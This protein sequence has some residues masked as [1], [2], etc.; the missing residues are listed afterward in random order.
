MVLFHYLEKD[1]ILYSNSRENF[2]I[3]F[4]DFE[5]PE[6]T[7]Y[8]FSS[9]KNIYEEILNKKKNNSIG[10]ST[11]EGTPNLT[12][13]TREKIEQ[14][15]I[16]NKKNKT[17]LFINNLIINKLY[18]LNNGTF[19]YDDIKNIFFVDNNSQ[20][21]AIKPEE[22]YNLKKNQTV[23]SNSSNNKL[24]NNQYH[25]M[26]EYQ[27][28]EKNDSIYKLTLLLSHNLNNDNIEIKIFDCNL[29]KHK[30]KKETLNTTKIKYSKIRENLDR[31]LSNNLYDNLSKRKLFSDEIFKIIL[32]NK[33]DL[34]NILK[35]KQIIGKDKAELLK[36]SFI[37]DLS[38]SNYINNLKTLIH[39]YFV[40]DKFV[41]TIDDD[42]KSVKNNTSK[43]KIFDVIEKSKNNEK[44]IY[45]VNI[46]NTYIQELINDK[47][48]MKKNIF[49]INYIKNT[50][51]NYIG[52]I[53]YIQKEINNNKFTINKD[54]KNNFIKNI[55]YIFTGINATENNNNNPYILNYGDKFVG[56]LNFVENNNELKAT[57]TFIHS[58]KYDLNIYEK[59]NILGLKKL[60]KDECINLL[61]NESTNLL[62]TFF[63]KE[64]ID[65]RL[66]DQYIDSIEKNNEKKDKN[67][68]FKKIFNQYLIDNNINF[69]IDV[70]DNNFILKYGNKKYGEFTITNNIKTAII[71]KNN[72]NLK[73][74]FDNKGLISIS[75]SDHIIP[76]NKLMKLDE[77]I[78]TISFHE[79]AKKF[80]VDDLNVVQTYIEKVMPSVIVIGTQHSAR[81]NFPLGNKDFQTIF[82]K[83]MRD[84]HY[85]NIFRKKSNVR[86]IELIK[87]KKYIKL[88]VYMNKNKCVKINKNTK[89]KQENKLL[90]Y[91]NESIQKN[92]SNDSINNQDKGSIIYKMNMEINGNIKNFIFVNTHIKKNDSLKSFKDLILKHELPNKYD[93][94][95]N[96]FFFG[97]LNAISENKNQKKVE[98]IKKHLI[99][100]KDLKNNK[101]NDKLYTMINEHI[102]LY[103]KPILSLNNK[104]KEIIKKFYQS[105]LESVKNSSKLFTTKLYSKT[106]KL[107]KLYSLN[108]QQINN[109]NDKEIEKYT[110]DNEIPSTPDKI[111]YAI[112]SND[113][114]I[115]NSDLK[116]FL[117]PSK[118][119]HK[120]IA[121]KAKLKL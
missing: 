99:Y 24:T 104:D 7:Y 113:I 73:T 17:K 90:I 27:L 95:Y 21:K 116:I 121:L 13:E 101:N 32:E 75:P 65:D 64:G 2:N 50:I 106:S 91:D 16:N 42:S 77:N 89:N 25:M 115:N 11:V 69:E 43:K 92:N 14:N 103:N 63:G 68:I 114:V 66:F 108:E 78:L 60:N 96:V 86:M 55:K 30:H 94:N 26:F 3:E 45:D 15:K 44:V 34:E 6:K 102:K 111:L 117:E 72:I 93:K 29:N 80:N 39:I 85:E 88:S 33:N 57:F 19:N 10:G 119:S 118:S 8:K 9:S 70:N 76:K 83:N 82:E 109:L 84:L 49:H 18:L 97:N 47:N 112:H 53:N 54:D 1:D 74:L 12:K 46:D 52:I 87:G 100:V 98:L 38:E 4:H 81:I 37:F 59:L 71:T 79:D 51:K 5:I 28:K 23:N 56:T 107:S 35:N 20:C 110:N 36:Q 105:L 58:E 62:Q 22:G 40:K 61:N 48:K 120:I 31:F 41:T 67:I